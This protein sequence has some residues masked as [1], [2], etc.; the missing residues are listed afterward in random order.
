MLKQL[1]E[2]FIPE[3]RYKIEDNEMLQLIKQEAQE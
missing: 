3:I 2:N 1:Y